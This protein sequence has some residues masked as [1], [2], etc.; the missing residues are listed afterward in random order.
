MAGGQL[1]TIGLTLTG[2]PPA[3]DAIVRLTSSRPDIAPV[4]ATFV[5]PVFG[6]PRRQLNIVPKVVSSPTTV[7]ITASYGLVSI[8]RTLT[9]APPTLKQIYLSPTTIIGGCRQSQGRVVLTGHA[10]TGGALVPLTNTNSKATVPQNVRL[11]AG[12]NSVS[13][14]VP[15]TPVTT[16]AAGVVTAAFGGVSQALNLSVRPIRAQTVTLAS[17]RVRGGTTVRGIVTLECPAVPGA[18]AVTFSSTNPSA[19]AATVPS[20]TIPTGGTSGAFSVRTSPVASDTT[21]TIYA[22][23]F[24][25]RKGVTLTV[26]P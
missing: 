22:T 19:A 15:T 5:M 2:P 23:V 14:T 11:P 17:A 18:I 26:T 7:Q 20:I 1:T 8:T 16:P 10:P 25:V 4:P 13:F 12:S 3:G 24:G 9:V 6:G 21:V